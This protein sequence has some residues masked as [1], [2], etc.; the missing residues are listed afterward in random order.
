MVPLSFGIEMGVMAVF[1]GTSSPLL[2]QTVLLLSREIGLSFLMMRV[3]L[4]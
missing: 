2:R 3:L 4:D 1:P